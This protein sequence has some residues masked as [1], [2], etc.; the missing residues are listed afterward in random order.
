[1][2]RIKYASLLCGLLLIFPAGKTRSQIINQEVSGNHQWWVNLGAGPGSIAS[3]FAMTAGMIYCYKFERS[4]ISA[5]M[6]G[7]TNN[8]P[9]AQRID[10]TPINYN[11]TDY[12]ILYGP[13]WQSQIMYVS[14]GAGLG[15]VRAGYEA[16]GGTTTK[17]SISL[18]IEA[19]LFWRP[20]YF[21][22][23]GLYSFASINFEKPM[24]GMM[25]C[26]QLGVW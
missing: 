26:C 9:T 8:N 12:G 19:Q 18:P 17:T 15:L 21:A 3:N 22:G 13:I 5:R 24:Y 20:T 1:M 16:K 7:I 6:L 4:L 23:I 10:R 14:V 2:R 25:L 11:M